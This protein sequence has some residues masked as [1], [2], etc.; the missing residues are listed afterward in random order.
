TP[1]KIHRPEEE[2]ACLLPEK[3]ENLPGDQGKAQIPRPPAGQRAETASGS[4]GYVPG[5]MHGTGGFF[6]S[7]DRQKSAVPTDLPAGPQAR[8][9]EGQSRFPPQALREAHQK[10]QGKQTRGVRHEGTRAPGGR[11]FLPGYDEL[12]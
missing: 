6:T 2:T 12:Q 8:R 11:A 7:E 5:G 10:G 3:E 9:A 4:A 1:F